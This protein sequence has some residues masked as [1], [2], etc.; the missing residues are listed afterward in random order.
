MFSYQRKLLLNIALVILSFPLVGKAVPVEES[1][2]SCS[3]YYQDALAKAPEYFDLK[4]AAMA[5]G[6][7]ALV[8]SGTVG[9]MC[10][11]VTGGACVLV[12]APLGAVVGVGV[13]IYHTSFVKK[14]LE[15]A[16]EF[17]A[18][19]EAGSGDTLI[20]VFQM[21]QKSQQSHASLPRPG[22][23]YPEFIKAMAE[24]NENKGLCYSKGHIELS[25]ES[26]GHFARAAASWISYSRGEIPTFKIPRH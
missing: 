26:L 23:T 3:D 14:D 9:F 24:L 5:A 10:H 8:A 6:A 20:Q 4:Q 13:N 7:G 11:M 17:F 15:Q 22:I 1:P 16:V 25:T 12:T 19:L 21:A 2:Y 18:Q